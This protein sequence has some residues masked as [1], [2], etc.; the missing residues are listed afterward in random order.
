MK[1]DG[2]GTFGVGKEAFARAQ[3]VVGVV[4]R[5]DGDLEGGDNEIEDNNGV[6]R[7]GN[8][9]TTN[10]IRGRSSNNQVM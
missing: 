8:W 4:G 5:G 7:E 3:E 1:V 9:A 10:S 6:K 2:G